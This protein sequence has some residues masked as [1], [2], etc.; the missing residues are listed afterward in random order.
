M[1]IANEQPFTTSTL[2]WFKITALRTE[3]LR[4]LLEEGV[5][6]LNGRRR[7]LHDGR[8]RGHLLAGTLLGRLVAGH[9]WRKVSKTS[10]MQHVIIRWV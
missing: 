3:A 8:G 6:G 7:L 10:P 1:G 2:G 9:G 4:A 5:H